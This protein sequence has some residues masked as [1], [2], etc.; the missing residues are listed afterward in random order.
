MPGSI[1][2]W[3]CMSS[4]KVCSVTQSKLPYFE[5]LKGGCDMLTLLI[6]TNRGSFLALQLGK[7]VIWIWFVKNSV[8]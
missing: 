4:T 8:P 6:Q 5:T 3:R 1:W 7:H 2:L